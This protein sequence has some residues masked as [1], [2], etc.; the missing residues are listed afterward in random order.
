[1]LFETF[2]NAATTNNHNSSRF[3]KFTKL[4][5]DAKGAVAAAEINVYLLEK[6]RLV[7]QASATRRAI[8]RAILARN[9]ARN[10]LTRP[11]ASSSS[12]PASGRSTLSTSSS[13]GHLHRREEAGLN[14]LEERGFREDADV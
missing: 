1:M 3:G 9:S 7:L 11:N 6:S 2:G 14:G 4:L 13:P 12:A 5:F 8:R 10:S